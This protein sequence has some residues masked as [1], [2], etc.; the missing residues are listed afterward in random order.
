MSLSENYKCEGQMSIFDMFPQDTWSGKMCPVPSVQTK[1]K[2]SEQSSRKRQ[3]SQTKLPLFLDLR[4]SG[5][6][7]VASWEMGG[8]LLGEFTMQGFGELPNVE[9]ESLLSQIL[10]DTPHPKYY[11]S[12][13]A[14][15]GI[16]RRAENRGKELPP[17]LKEALIRQSLS[18]ND[19]ENRGGGKGI[20][21]QHERVGALST[22]N[23]QS[24]MRCQSIG[25]NGDIAGTLDA[26]YFKG[27]GERQG[28]E[29]D[30]VMMV[31]GLDRAS[32]NQGQNAQY[33]FSIQEET[34]QTLVSRGPGGGTSQT[35]GALC[36]RDFKGVG[37]QYVAEGKCIIQN[38]GCV[39]KPP[40]G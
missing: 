10:E 3:G 22:L 7:A 25:I 23:N 19:V 36:A 21:I 9:R 5:H 18:K 17:Q 2:I 16:L 35:V 20:L 31:L 15:Q 11:L 34:A 29:R 40:N 12:P 30:V 33:D 4:E 27:C 32:F 37:N 6:R 8:L 39:G 13:K 28:V 26:N 24:V 38:V 14:C 1:E